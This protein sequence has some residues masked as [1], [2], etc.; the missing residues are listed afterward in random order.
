MATHAAYLKNLYESTDKR[1][2]GHAP[3]KR[4]RD[5]L[6]GLGVLG[7]AAPNTRRASAQNAAQQQVNDVLANPSAAIADMS[8]GV[9]PS[10]TNGNGADD[11]AQHFDFS[12][13]QPI[14]S[15]LVQG[16]SGQDVGSANVDTAAAALSQHYNMQVPHGDD[17]GGQ[18]GNEADDSNLG[19]EDSNAFQGLDGGDVDVL[20]ADGSSSRK[21]PVGSEEWHKVRKDN[22]KEGSS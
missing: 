8:S 18:T 14:E 5:S 2:G 21:P 11:G 17:F 7:R 3:G 4:K 22:H 19:L 16:A 10:S 6:E 13:Q 12:L 1:R 20:G 15:S 9:F